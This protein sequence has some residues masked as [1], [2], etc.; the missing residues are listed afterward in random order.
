MK[1]WLDVVD[2]FKTVDIEDRL[3]AFEAVGYR[4][5]FPARN[6]IFRAFRETPFDKVK[7]VILGQDPYPNRAHAV[8]LAFAV[9]PGTNP[10]PKSLINILTEL[11][12]DTGIQRSNGDLTDWTAQGVFL[13]NT[14]LTVQEGKP[15]LHAGLWRKF[16]NEVIQRL[17]EHRDNLVFVLWGNHAISKARLINTDKH[18]VITSVH[19]SPHAAYRGFFGSRPF[20]R[21]NKHLISKNITPIN[22]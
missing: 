1:H 5:I 20:S 4:D 22:W 17:S 7:V 14:A 15:G 18:A 16:T 9:P 19:P 6:D 3:E 10:L 21:I 13:L 11:E 2:Y 8:G 12:K